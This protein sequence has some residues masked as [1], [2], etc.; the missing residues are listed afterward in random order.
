MV[1]HINNWSRIATLP[2]SLIC[3]DGIGTAMRQYE[4]Y[5]ITPHLRYPP[6]LF[7]KYPP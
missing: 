1:Y 4:R 3:D 6:A 5:K 7:H 2:Q